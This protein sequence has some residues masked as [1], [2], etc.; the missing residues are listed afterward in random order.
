MVTGQESGGYPHLQALVS[1]QVSCWPPGQPGGRRISSP[2][3]V[4]ITTGEPPGQSGGRRIS[5]P[6]GV[7][8]T[9]RELLAIR[10][11]RRQEDILTSRRWYHYSA[12]N[13]AGIYIMHNCSLMDTGKFRIFKHKCTRNFH[14]LI[15]MRKIKQA[16]DNR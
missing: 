12:D 8:I 4:G 16:T 1:L 9:T 6:P 3:G 14:F 2:P 15:A 5:S 13:S 10:T 7:G 11:A